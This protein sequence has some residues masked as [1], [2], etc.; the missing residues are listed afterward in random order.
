MKNTFLKISKF[1]IALV[2]LLS[3][4]CVFSKSTYAK[5][6]NV[7]YAQDVKNYKKIFEL[8]EKGRFKEADKV[9]KNIK[10]DILMGYVLHQRFMSPYYKTPFKEVK[11]WLLKYYDMPNANDIYKLG[12]QKG[13]K[14]EL[15]RPKKEARRTQYFNDDYKNNYQMIQYSYKHLP[16]KEKNEVNY[17]LK[18]FNNRLKRGYT[19]NARQ[20]LE[21]PNSKKY[22]ARNDYLRMEAYLAFTYFLNNEDDMAILWA[23]EPAEQINFYLANWTLGLVYW[24]QGDYIKSRDYFKNIAFTK[25]VPIDMLTAS[26]YWAYRANEKIDDEELKD[27]S[28]IFLE[29]ASSYPKTF[30]GI[31]ANK[32]L[33]KK[34]EIEWEE[35]LLTIQNAREISSWQGGMRAL[36]L[37]Q[38]D[39]KEEA[40]QELKFLINTADN[41]YSDDLI[42]A[43]LAV[44][45]ISNMPHLSINVANYIKQYS[46]SSTFATCTYPTIDIEL[47]EGWSVDKALVNALIRQESR[48]NPKAKS[49]AGARGLMQIM[50]STASFIMR[51]SSLRKKQKSKLFEEELNLKIGQMY[52]EYLLS[53]PLVNGNLFKFLVAYNA[54]PGNLKKQMDRI[55][56]PD[57]DPLFFIESI[58]LKETRIY[59]ER[60]MANFWIYR[61]KL[62]QSSESL[63]DVINNMWP[64]YISK[65]DIPVNKYTDEEIEYLEDYL[66]DKE[67]ENSEDEEDSENNTENIS[68]IENP[69]I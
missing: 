59:V 52:I 42:N 47:K 40:G 24:R 15:R 27:D 21:N 36:A 32:K 53:S 50:P 65:G 64:I 30:Y 31:L 9:I 66:E 68:D 23:R 6:P 62:N 48:F 54:G 5:L 22:F 14:R 7:I 17:M 34:W 35:P 63:D 8:Q 56:N 38:L 26:A 44:A 45:E 25:Q 69:E 60:V 58:N 13:A 16:K 2:I 1:L 11:E 10:N 39:M 55:N 46:D 18:I 51:D 19:K 29:T 41:D 37:L 3:E 57:D 49:N 20:I 28:D 33:N 12:L 61:N 67:K 43:V 4:L